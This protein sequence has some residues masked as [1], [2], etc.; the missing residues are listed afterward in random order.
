MKH[1]SIVY[2][3][4]TSLTFGCKDDVGKTAG[5]APPQQMKEAARHGSSIHSPSAQRRLQGKVVETMN[6]S[7]YTYVA[8]EEASKEKVWAAG[9]ETMVKVGDSIDIPR[10]MEMVDFQSKSLGRT[11]KSI[12]FVR[13]LAGQSKGAIAQAIT[14]RVSTA[15][16]APSLKKANGVEHAPT[17]P[18]S[19]QSNS[20]TYT[21]SELFA[22][23]SSLAGKQVTVRGKV[24]KFSPA[25]LGTNWL[26]LQDGS[27][28]AALKNHDLTVTSQETAS[29]GDTI[30]V[31]GILAKDKDLGA[32]YKYPV[33]VE[34]AVF[35]NAVAP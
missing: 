28:T 22:Q 20:K 23:S 13:S 18:V 21:I 6:A 5:Y 12:Y 9:P 19:G 34:S 27:G 3:I 33:I 10:G 26:H 32:G 15:L 16:N 11:F 1:L 35:E 8:V 24:V 4:A 14:P 25:I 17:R 29:V 2:A 7:G 31:S 30:V